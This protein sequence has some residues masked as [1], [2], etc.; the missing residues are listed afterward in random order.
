MTRSN[1]RIKGQVSNLPYL[2]GAG[3]G[4]GIVR[5]TLHQG[6]RRA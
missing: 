5:V 4:M 2:G 3:G 1:T 6:L